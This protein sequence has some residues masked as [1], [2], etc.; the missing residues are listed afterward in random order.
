MFWK[1]FQVRGTKPSFIIDK[2]S[3]D[4]TIYFGSFD[5]IIEATT[6]AQLLSKTNL[7]SNV[8][9]EDRSVVWKWNYK[10]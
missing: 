1:R 10:F 5:S 6:V 4:D 2:L 3:P 8:W 7:Y 9:V